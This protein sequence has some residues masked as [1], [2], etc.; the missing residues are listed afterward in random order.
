M[1]C[2]QRLILLSPSGFAAAKAYS[3]VFDWPC[4]MHDFGYRNYGGKNL[5]LDRTEKARAWV[6]YRLLVETQRACDNT[7]RGKP[8]RLKACKA[9][10][11]A[12]YAAVHAGGNSAFTRD[13]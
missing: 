1:Q 4:E 6:D 9:A 7:S 11:R 2:A 13:D 8:I 3:R 12:F 5:K 10:S